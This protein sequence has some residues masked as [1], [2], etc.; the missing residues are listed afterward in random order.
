MFRGTYEEERQQS[1]ADVR[2]EFI[3]ALHPE[4]HQEV[5]CLVAWSDAV[6]AVDGVAEEVEG[7]GETEETEVGARVAE[8]EPA[9]ES[10]KDGWEG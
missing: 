1:G 6:G 8:R 4:G 10:A 9:R 7:E 3:F 2:G 5:E